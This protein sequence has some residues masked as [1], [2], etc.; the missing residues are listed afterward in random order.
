LILEAISSISSNVSLKKNSP[1][2]L[3]WPNTIA[4]CDTSFLEGSVV[5][6]P[7]KM[8]YYSNGTLMAEF[9][10]STNNSSNT[11]NT[12][13]PVINGTCPNINS[14]ANMNNIAN[15]GNMINNNGCKPK[16]EESRVN[17][18]YGSNSSSNSSNSNNAYSSN[19]FSAFIFKC[20]K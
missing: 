16:P 20:Q 1:L 14:N 9:M 17:N 12:S 5:Y 15:S 4:E 3:F 2:S 10:K 11:N 8:P 13:M 7:S 19:D 18:S 6:S